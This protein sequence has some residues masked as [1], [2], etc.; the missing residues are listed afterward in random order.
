MFVLVSKEK[1]M[2]LDMFA[3]S[4]AK[5]D[6]NEQFAIA[7]GTDRTEL[8]YW[9]KFNAL[10]GWMEDF[11]RANGFSGEFNCV[12]VQLSPVVIDQLEHDIAVRALQ[13]R[14][15]FFFGSQDIYPEDIESTKKF[16]ADAREV[17]ASGGEVYYDSWW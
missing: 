5:N 9:R 17:F 11:A 2:G 15:G 3:W 14:E 6:A 8:A 12:P 1:I 16:I 13:P 4:V 7:E 10:H